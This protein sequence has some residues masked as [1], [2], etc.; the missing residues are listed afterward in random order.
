MKLRFGKSLFVG[1]GTGPLLR[2]ACGDI[3]AMIDVSSS[4]EVEGRLGSLMIIFAFC[5]GEGGGCTGLLILNEEVICEMVEEPA[6]LALWFDVRFRLGIDDLESFGGAF[7]L[8]MA[9]SGLSA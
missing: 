6:L 1:L 9:F 8:R 5:M 4:P 2:A 3:G 7:F